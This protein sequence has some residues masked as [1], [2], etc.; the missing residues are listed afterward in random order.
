MNATTGLSSTAAPEAIRERF[1][2]LLQRSTSSLHMMLDDVMNLA[3]L[4][5]GHEQLEVKKFDAARLL[6]DLCDELQTQAHE[7]SLYLKY[8][9]P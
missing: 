2:L 5:A 9:G 8:G 6:R 4:Q 3:R 1:L 7:R